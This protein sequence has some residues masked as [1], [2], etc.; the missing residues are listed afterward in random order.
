VQSKRRAKPVLQNSLDNRDGTLS[1]EKEETRD[2]Y[3]K[4]QSREKKIRKRDMFSDISTSNV[5]DNIFN[6][7]TRADFNRR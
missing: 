4:Q 7:K 2:E 5:A 1:G 6:D 3:K